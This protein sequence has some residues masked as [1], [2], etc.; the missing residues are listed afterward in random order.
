[1]SYDFSEYVVT[2]K[3]MPSWNHEE[4]A[5]LEEAIKYCSANK[6]VSIMDFVKWN[7]K[8]GNINRKFQT[9]YTYVLKGVRYSK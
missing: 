1:M 7:I 9:V 8:K 5:W 6:G 3:G 4:N 2:A